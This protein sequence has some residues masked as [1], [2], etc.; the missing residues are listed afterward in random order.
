MP[1]SLVYK[2]K[3]LNVYYRPFESRSDL[4]SLGTRS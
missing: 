4:P 3:L 2:Y 1:C